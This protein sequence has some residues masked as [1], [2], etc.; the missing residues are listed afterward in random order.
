MRN[1]LFLAHRAPFPP[2]RGDKIRAYNVLKYL[3]AR[4][5]VHLVAFADDPRDLAAQG[6]TDLC[7]SHRIVPRTKSNARAAVEALATGRPVSLAAFADTAFRSAVD[8]MLAMEAIDASYLY[9]SAMAQYLPSPTVMDFC[10]VDSVKFGEYARAAAGPKRWLYRREERLL[11]AYDRSVSGAA[12]ASVFVSAGEAGLFRSIGGG[13]RIVV[14]ENGIDTVRFDPEADFAAIEVEG[15]LIV[16]TGQMDYAPNIAA[17]RWFATEVLPRIAEARFAIVGRAP[18]AEVSALASERVIVTGEVADARGWIAAAAVVV[19][20]LRIARG[21]QNK[22]LEAMA[23]AKAV[24][25]SSA[26]ADGIDHKGTLRTADD[27]GNFA[28]QVET[29]IADP[30]DA[31]ALGS[32]ARRQVQA[33]YGWEA[34]LAPL[35]HLLGLTSQ[36]VRA[37]LVEAPFCLRAGRAE[38]GQHFDKLSANGLGG[39][40]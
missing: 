1:I 23:M 4:A 24:V 19:A 40:R 31:H 28:A 18:T 22:V 34:C 5:R 10:D 26:A 27:A 2:D 32:A 3:S 7:A 11:G 36:S 17:V 39:V 37:E 13:G 33:R 14:V 29:L 30:A 15:P 25:A 16:F 38:Q 21:I 9:S 35:D 8:E 6:L 20:P 12:G